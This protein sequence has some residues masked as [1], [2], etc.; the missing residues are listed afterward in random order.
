MQLKIL[1]ETILRKIN[2]LTN[3]S[4]QNKDAK[5]ELTIHIFTIFACQK[6]NEICKNLNLLYKIVHVK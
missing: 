4:D 5:I 1:L 6:V 2:S 3:Q